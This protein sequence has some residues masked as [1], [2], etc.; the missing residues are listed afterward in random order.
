MDYR[1]PFVVDPGK[2]LRLKDR[3]PSFKGH[4]ESHETA[5]AELEHY[6]QKLADQQSLMYA[7]K[8]HAL[9]IVLQALDAGGK[10]GALRPY[11]R[12]RDGAVRER[13]PDSEVLPAYQQGRAAGAL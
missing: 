13:N 6:R 10:D 2:K 1:K 4:H 5:A 7:E 8:K 12:F 11:P 9:L 3:D